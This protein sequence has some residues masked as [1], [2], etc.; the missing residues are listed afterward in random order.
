MGRFVQVSS[1]K[2]FNPLSTI[3]VHFADDQGTSE[4]AADAGDPRSEY[5]R[6]F[7]NIYYLHSGIFCGP[8]DNRV[9]YINFQGIKLKLM[10]AF[11]HLLFT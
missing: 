11:V 6:L 8:E 2:K 5:L 10:C 7:V 1:A 9:I 3:S 4:G